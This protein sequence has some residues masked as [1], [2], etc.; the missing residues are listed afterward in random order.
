[1]VLVVV[2]PHATFFFTHP[3]TTETYTLSLH[4]ALPIS[5]NLIPEPRSSWI[6]PPLIVPVRISDGRLEPGPTRWVVHAL[7]LQPLTLI[8]CGPVLELSCGVVNE[9]WRFMVAPELSAT[10]PALL[11]EP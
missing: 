7:E 3:A 10:E 8:V 9:P 2:V 5:W 1:M 6:T 4:D 11:Q